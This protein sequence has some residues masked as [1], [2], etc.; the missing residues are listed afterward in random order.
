MG[1]LFGTDG[2]RGVANE[3]PVTT[4]MALAIGRAAA[5]V[6]GSNTSAA[7]ASPIIIGRDTRL[8]GSMLECALAAGICSTGADVIL[9]G[10]I[11]TPAV[12]HLAREMRCAAGIVIS[13]SHNPFEDNGI[14][15][16]TADGCKL[17]PEQEERIE[18]LTLS[19]AP[20][21]SLP[22]S[23]RIG[24]VTSA[25]GN[26]IKSYIEFCKSSFPSNQTLN[27]IKVALDC[28]NGAASQ[29]A[30]AIFAALGADVTT[31]HAAPDGININKDC[32]SQHTSD[33]AAKVIETGANIGLAFD[34]DADRLI[35]IDETGRE[36]TG[37]HIIAI[38]A[39]N[40]RAQRRLRNDLV[41]LTPMSNL[42][43]RLAFDKLGIRWLDAGV[44]DRLVVELM[45]KE[46]ATLGGEQSGHVIFL[47]KHSTGDGIITALQLLSAMLAAN[48]KLSELASIFEP[49]PQTLINITV[50]EKPAIETLPE[51]ARAIAD[52]ELALA[53]RGRVLVR[54]SGTQPM[55]RVM[56][57]AESSDT[58]ESIAAHI[59]DLL[60]KHI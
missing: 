46:G 24:R 60:K 51:V 45:K 35:A 38:C 28:A 44:G 14:K 34:G 57:E 25:D 33:L 5:I 49:A 20:P 8:S 31:I 50:R 6:L 17:T 23:E 39:Q 53:G 19:P 58:C 9:T 55:C 3:Y 7:N 48:A 2:V 54:Y 22:A 4:E 10:V 36:L 52:A 32:G 12:A 26:A 1:T 15:I 16:F 27:G 11:P 43:L 30:P 29:V 13:A 47:D 59:A 56:V 21:V 42:G 37:D 40:L 18:Q 41:I